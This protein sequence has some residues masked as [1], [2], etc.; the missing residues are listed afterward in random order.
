MWE[1]WQV[2]KIQAS[3][4]KI[5]IKRCPT[6]MPVASLSPYSGTGT[7]FIFSTPINTLSGK[8][9]I[10]DRAEFIPTFASA[11]NATDYSLAGRA[12]IARVHD[13]HANIWGRNN[14]LKDY[15]GNYA[16]PVQAKFIENKLVVTGYYSDT[17][18]IKE[19][20]KVGDIITKI[21]GQPV[22]Q[23]VKNYLYITPA[24]NYETQ[25]RDLPYR[26][27]LHS[28]QDSLTLELER[29]HKTLVVSVHCIDADHVNYAIDF[30][31]NPN[32][33][34]YARTREPLLSLMPMTLGLSLNASSTGKSDLYTDARRIVIE[35][36]LYVH[37]VENCL[38]MRDQLFL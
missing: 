19:K 11:R 2:S 20:L 1:W 38:V 27:L 37:C 28:R 6:L 8:T 29:N 24:S 13:T 18:F 34:S 16:P 31:P 33:S 3:T 14:A 21:N 32:D 12:I 15:F 26:S 17:L 35:H 25:L 30:N 22:E 23:L 36:Q 9:G 10:K 5:R 4:M 7:S